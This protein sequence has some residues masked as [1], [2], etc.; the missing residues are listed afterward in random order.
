MRQDR[1]V[2][3][4]DAY[5]AEM[6]YPRN[7]WY[8]AAW[9]DEVRA[10]EPLRRVL[11]DTPVVL[12]RTEDGKPAALHDRCPHRGAL[13]SMGKQ[14]GDEVQCPYHGIQFGPDGRC[15]HVPSQGGTPAALA[16]QG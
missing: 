13:L 4:A 12:Y 6:G 8:V 2:N 5:P 7:Q 16:V 10:G 11:L 14:I 1:I 9:S 15:T 3:R